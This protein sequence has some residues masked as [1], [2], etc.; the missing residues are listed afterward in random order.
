MA[1]AI[2]AQRNGEKCQKRNCPSSPQFWCT[3]WGGG[4]YHIIF[5]VN[6]LTILFHFLHSKDF[7]K[8]K[9][10]C[11]RDSGYF[12]KLLMESL[13]WAGQLL[14]SQ[15]R[16]HFSGPRPTFFVIIGEVARGYARLWLANWFSARWLAE[17]TKRPILFSISGAIK[18][19]L[20]RGA[21]KW[22]PRKLPMR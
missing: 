18:L 2:S 13:N 21:S 14:P 10:Q 20:M 11:S 6:Q 4:H 9:A 1:D 19:D 17:K 16:S 22:R 7:P 3:V 8:D 5:K 12:E 15:S